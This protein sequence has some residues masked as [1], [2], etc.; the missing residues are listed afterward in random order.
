MAMSSDVPLSKTNTSV[1]CTFYNMQTNVSEDLMV[2]SVSSPMPKFFSKSS[3]S[4]KTYADRLIR[5]AMTE[6]VHTMPMREK[7]ASMLPSL[8][9]VTGCG[10]QAAPIFFPLLHVWI[11][12]V[13]PCDDLTSIPS[14]NPRQLNFIHP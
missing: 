9:V 14:L 2:S 11:S 8:L 12:E 6:V 10:L 4:L 13:E 1:L 3:C 7:L 5:I